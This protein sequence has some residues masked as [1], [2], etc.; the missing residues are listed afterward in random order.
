[1]AVPK[2]TSPKMTPKD[3]MGSMG[4]STQAVYGTGKVV[5]GGST[6][7]NHYVLKP[8]SKTKFPC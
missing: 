4:K 1:M 5:K 3:V 8:T 6:A 2:G 7:P